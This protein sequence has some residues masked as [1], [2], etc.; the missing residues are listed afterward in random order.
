MHSTQHAARFCNSSCAFL[1]FLIVAQSASATGDNEG[2]TSIVPV[3]ENS[4][5]VAEFNC[6][7]GMES[8]HFD[9]KPDGKFRWERHGCLGVYGSVEGSFDVA[10]GV[11]V[12]NYD[13]EPNAFLGSGRLIPIR[14][15][16]R[17]YLAPEETLA[18]FRRAL[19]IFG[20]TQYFQ[21]VAYTRKGD[22][23]KPALGVPV[24]PPPW[25]ELFATLAPVELTA[26]ITQAWIGTYTNDVTYHVTIDAGAPHGFRDGMELFFTAGSQTTGHACLAI[27]LEQVGENYAYGRVTRRCYDAPS[28]SL[29]AH[30]GDT[31]RVLTLVERE[32]ESADRQLRDGW[33]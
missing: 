16:E 27:R 32:E 29:L 1:F 18:R 30:V 8:L 5:V 28:S 6:S 19:A 2:T 12:L 17:L 7:L 21:R 31:L 9:L 33:D 3:R 23:F 25:D 15:G 13:G 14:W 22:E 11:V 4:E 24:A 26:R 10:D 20:D